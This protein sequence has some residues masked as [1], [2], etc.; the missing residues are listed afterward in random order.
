MGGT[1]VNF[2]SKRGH[3]VPVGGDKDGLEVF[4]GE[5]VRIHRQRGGRVLNAFLEG[6]SRIGGVGERLN[7][8]A[9]FVNQNDVP[10]TKHLNVKRPLSVFGVK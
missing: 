1:E 8:D 9:L 4:F 10:I 5:F 7:D 6:S 3:Q 2:A